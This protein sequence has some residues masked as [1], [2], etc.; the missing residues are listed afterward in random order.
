M[1]KQGHSLALNL[2][3]IQYW[4]MPLALPRVKGFSSLRFLPEKK[5]SDSERKLPLNDATLFTAV[6]TVARTSPSTD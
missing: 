6:S 2:L 1:S 5:K 4:K 3:T